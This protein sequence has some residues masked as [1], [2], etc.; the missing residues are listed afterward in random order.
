MIKVQQLM[1]LLAVTLVGFVCVPLAAVGIERDDSPEGELQGSRVRLK[2]TVKSKEYRAEQWDATPIEEEVS[3]ENTL[4]E[5]R[6]K[7]KTKPQNKEYRN[8]QWDALPVE[9]EEGSYEDTL[10]EART[11]LKPRGNGSRS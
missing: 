9:E 5:A 1:V 10:R 7:L 2:K 4:H 3:N 11:R 8:E 6:T